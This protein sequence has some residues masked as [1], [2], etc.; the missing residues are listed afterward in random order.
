MKAKF[1]N[2]LFVLLIG[3]LLAAACGSSPAAAPAAG[4]AG[5]PVVGKTKFEGTCSSCHG[6]DAT[7]LPGLG[8]DLVTSEFA[9]GLTD[10]ELLAF[11]KTGRPAS[12]PANTTSVDMPPKGGNPALTD[13]DLL[14]IIAYLRTLEK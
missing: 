9:K 11:V 8:K 13:Q 10:A 5:D 7:G 12:D 4:P 1:I 14:D 3:A 2:L 6:P